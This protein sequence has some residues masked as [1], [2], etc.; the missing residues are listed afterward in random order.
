MEVIAETID[1]LQAYLVSFGDMNNE[2]V[3]GY[4]SLI[5]SCLDYFLT[6]SLSATLSIEELKKEIGRFVDQYE[7]NL[8]AIDSTEIVSLNT[9]VKDFINQYKERLFSVKAED[10]EK[11]P[12]IRRLAYY[13]FDVENISNIVNMLKNFLEVFEY[14]HPLSRYALLQLLLEIGECCNDVSTFNKVSYTDIPWLLSTSL[15]NRITHQAM[16]ELEGQLKLNAFLSL[17]FASAENKLLIQLIKHCVQDLTLFQDK[18]VRLSF[19]SDTVTWEMLPTIDKYAEAK[20]QFKND[21][22][23][24]NVPEPSQAFYHLH[25]LKEYFYEVCHKLTSNDSLIIA[26]E[27]DKKDLAAE[28]PGISKMKETLL[29]LDAMDKYEEVINIEEII[30]KL[31][32][33]IKQIEVLKTVSFSDKDLLVTLASKFIYAY[34]GEI[35]RGLE[36]KKEFQGQVTDVLRVKIRAIINKRNDYCTQFLC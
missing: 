1:A 31:E 5:K 15:R 11:L 16:D 20:S 2:R 3:R 27:K 17:S 7:N 12:N 26:I 28:N 25:I 21:Q 8:S 19:N 23:Q 32:A 4:I 9:K 30:L 6:S 24:L 13:M 29:S 33:T 35:A 34:L 36:Q 22:S 10:G 14:E 18:I